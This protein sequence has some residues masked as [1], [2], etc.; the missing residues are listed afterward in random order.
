MTTTGVVYLH[1][2]KPSTS[3]A[4]SINSDVSEKS[5]DKSFL[6]RL[7]HRSKIRNSD[8]SSRSGDSSFGSADMMVMTPSPHTH[9]LLS[10]PYPRDD[11]LVGRSRPSTLVFSTHGGT[12]PCRLS[13]PAVTK[14]SDAGSIYSVNTSAAADMYRRS[15]REREKAAMAAATDC[16]YVQEWGFFIKC[17]SEG[18]FNVS[19]PPDPPPRRPEFNHLTAP[20]P[21]DERQRLKAVKA[22]NTILPTAAQEKCHRLV[23]LARKVFQT[24]MACISLVDENLELVKAEHSFGRKYITRADSI[25]AHV[26]LGNEPMVVLDTVKDWRLRGNPLTQDSPH[27]RFYAGAPIVT[28]EGHTIGV[29]AVFDT[30]PR[31][32]FPAASRRNLMDF[33]RLA[34]TE[35]EMVMEDREVLRQHQPTKIVG[36]T[37]VT[38]SDS[39]SVISRRGLLSI[40]ILKGIEADAEKMPPVSPFLAGEASE[41]LLDSPTVPIRPQDSFVAR[42]KLRDIN[43]SQEEPMLPPPE[44]P[45]SFPEE[46]FESSRR[47][48]EHIVCP[49]SPSTLLSSSSALPSPSTLP[50]SICTTTTPR[51]KQHRPLPI[52]PVP[53]PGTSTNSLSPIQSPITSRI[54]ATPGSITSMVEATYATSL[55]AR[56]LDYDFVYLLRVTS[57]HTLSSPLVPIDPN[58]QKLEISTKVLVAHGLPDPPPIFDGGLHLRALRSI[59][60]LIFQNPVAE[61]SGDE[62]DV[63]YQLGILLP[64]VRDC[65]ECENEESGGGVVLA[66]FARKASGAPAL[67]AD[68]VRLLREFGEALKD[69]LVKVDKRRSVHTRGVMA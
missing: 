23:L 33:A 12:S 66:A 37:K 30:Q 43:T 61:D 22:C 10:K 17:Y 19:N 27:L 52:F 7:F 44:T 46:D 34:M 38:D 8:Y 25:G 40:K 41:V 47:Q 3:S 4:F 42:P 53:H 35:F 5:I 45:T 63:G 57:T 50:S 6:R 67:R 54:P 64:L 60:G 28:F 49:T 29:F 18:R 51:Y 69:I 20:A 31:S 16:K 39:E 11:V 65:E 14:T 36:Q 2:S 24:R 55:I 68:E 48:P 13:N 56:S 62:D 1:T 58:Q 21:P 9:P 59:G 15:L 32:A 26:L